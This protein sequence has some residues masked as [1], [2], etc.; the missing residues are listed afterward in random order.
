M[1]NGGPNLFPPQASPTFNLGATYT[2]R[3]TKIGGFTFNLNYSYT[4][5]QQTYPESTD[6][7]ALSDSA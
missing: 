1:A 5:K 3:E 2:L 4:A 7:A 6:P